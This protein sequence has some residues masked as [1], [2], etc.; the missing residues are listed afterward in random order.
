LIPEPWALRTAERKEQPIGIGTWGS[1]S[2]GDLFG[3][4]ESSNDQNHEVYSKYLC[5]LRSSTDV[6]SENRIG[7][8]ARVVVDPGK[9]RVS[10]TDPL[11]E[12]G[13]KKGNLHPHIRTDAGIAPNKTCIIDSDIGASIGHVFCLAVPQHCPNTVI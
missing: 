4:G 8:I 3:G 1:P 5:I 12:R 10:S 11:K 6:G 2:I 9:N 13:W 7:G